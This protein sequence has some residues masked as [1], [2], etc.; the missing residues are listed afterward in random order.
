[1]AEFFDRWESRVWAHFERLARHHPAFS[2]TDMRYAHER[3]DE[4]VN[5]VPR[6]I[7]QTLPLARF[8]A[9]NPPQRPA[10]ISTRRDFLTGQLAAARGRRELDPPIEE[11]TNDESMALIANAYAAETARLAYTVKNDIDLD[12]GDLTLFPE[13]FIERNSPGPQNAQWATAATALVL[14][15]QLSR[16]ALATTPEWFA[17]DSGLDADPLA[18]LQEAVARDVVKQGFIEYGTR[19]VS[20]RRCSCM[21]ALWQRA[22]QDTDYLLEA[23]RTFSTTARKDRTEEGWDAYVAGTGLRFFLCMARAVREDSYA[24]ESDAGAVAVAMLVHNRVPRGAQWGNARGF[25]ETLKRDRIVTMAP[26]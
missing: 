3:I 18:R 25:Y 24:M 26:W 15:S 6:W 13:N 14:R 8:N 12:S 19:L 5:R 23:H 2:E 11:L 9:K 7:W 20:Y 1:M 10:H 16:I 17:V 21:P 4:L 22:K